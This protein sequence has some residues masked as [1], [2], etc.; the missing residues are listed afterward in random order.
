MV[1]MSYMIYLMIQVLLT[2]YGYYEKCICI[3]YSNSLGYMCDVAE[4]DNLL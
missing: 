2:M 4:N 1:I 3:F